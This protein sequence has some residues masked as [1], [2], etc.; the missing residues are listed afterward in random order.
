MS[1]NHRPVWAERD[2]S[3]AECAGE[4]RAIA[5]R[6]GHIQ[7]ASRCFTDLCYTFTP[8]TAPLASFTHPLSLLSK[9]PLAKNIYGLIGP[10]GGLGF[11]IGKLAVLRLCHAARRQLPPLPLRRR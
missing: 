3:V 2:V 4:G 11:A 6:W 5:L 10:N 9:V 1:Q 8:H 7:A